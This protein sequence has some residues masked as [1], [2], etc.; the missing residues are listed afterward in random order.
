M[1]YRCSGNEA[2]PALHLADVNIPAAHPALRIITFD[3]V[4]LHS[5]AAR[6]LVFALDS[7]WRVATG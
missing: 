7:I 3:R 2:L 4:V 6:Y 5:G 1:E